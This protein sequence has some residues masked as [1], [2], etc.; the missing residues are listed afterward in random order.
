MLRTPAM[1]GVVAGGVNRG[2]PARAKAPNLGS[3]PTR[4]QIEASA[5]RQ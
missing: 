3:R 2:L 1:N 4:R 5:K